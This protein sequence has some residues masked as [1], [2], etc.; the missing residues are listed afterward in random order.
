M[1]SMRKIFFLIGI[2]CIISLLLWGGFS[3]WEQFQGIGPAVL[4]PL[5]DIAEI[6]EETPREEQQSKLDFPLILPEGFSISVFAKNL[7]PA[8][9]MTRDP[10]GNLL[11]SVTKEGKVLALLDKNGDGNSERTVSVVEGLNRPHGLLF[12]EDKLYVAESD[13]VAVYDYDSKLCGRLI[14]RKLLTC[15]MEV[16]ILQEL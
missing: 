7:G 5:G 2:V 14:R 9:V 11:V 12:F 1:K 10:A 15:P 6:I 13:Q 4:P 3:I 16:I 8:R